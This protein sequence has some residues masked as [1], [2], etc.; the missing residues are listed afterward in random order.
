MLL[1]GALGAAAV[2]FRQM[3]Q[4]RRSQL[5]AEGARRL[6]TARSRADAARPLMDLS[7]WEAAVQGAERALSLARSGSGPGQFLERLKVE[8]DSIRSGYTQATKDLRTRQ[9]LDEAFLLATGIQSEGRVNA[10]NFDLVAAE[11]SRAFK[12]YGI[13]L[14]SL[15]N[16]DAVRIIRNSAIR[17]TLVVSL[18]G[19]VDCLAIPPHPLPGAPLAGLGTVVQTLARTPLVLRI[20][21]LAAKPMPTPTRNEI[22]DALMR[23]DSALLRRI[24]TC[25]KCADVAT[26]YTI[27]LGA[28]SGSKRPN[29]G[30]DA[31]AQQGQ[32][33][34]P[35][36]FLAQLLPGLRLR[37]IPSHHAMTR[38]SALFTAALCI[39]PDSPGMRYNLAAALFF[40]RS[41][42]MGPSRSATPR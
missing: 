10:F 9:R 22:R 3:D 16:R 4:D 18:D 14:D 25:A 29:R 24:A 31:T 6:E 7:G 5:M 41:T 17:D 30:C 33:P 40:K 32:G 1:A 21:T 23:R 2:W 39:R 15:P 12:E 11:Y 27:T 34:A 8:V 20:V 35:R 36:R 28:G 42:W 37:R 13:D 38:Q 26:C 19:Y